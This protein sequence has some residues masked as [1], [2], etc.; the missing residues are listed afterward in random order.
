MYMQSTLALA[1]E[2]DDTGRWE[3]GAPDSLRV[4]AI[5]TGDISRALLERSG[6]QLARVIDT[7]TAISVPKTTPANN[8][9]TEAAS[10]TT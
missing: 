4:W 7:G 3:W 8:H 9:P 6:L 10:L 1:S 2:H 5:V